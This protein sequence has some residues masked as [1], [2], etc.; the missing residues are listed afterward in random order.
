M[1]EETYEAGDTKRNSRISIPLLI[2]FLLSLGL[3]AYLFYD[4]YNNNYQDGRSLKEINAELEEVLSQ[5]EFSRDSLQSEYDLLSQQYQN[6]YNESEQLKIE[7]T[8]ALQELGQKKV[9]IRQLLARTANP[10]DLIKAKSEIEQLKQQLDD[11]QVKLRQTAEARDKYAKVA[12]VEK[13]NAETLKNQ[14]DRAYKEKQVLEEKVSNATLRISDLR[15]TPLRKRR[16]GMEPTTKSSKVEE[17]EISFIILESPLIKEGEKE[18]KLRIIGTN[19]EVLGANNGLLADSDELFSMK[20]DFTYDGS[21]EKFKLT[22]KQ[23]E[24]YKSGSHFV[25]LWS[26]GKMITRSPFNLD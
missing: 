12:E 5:T 10:K 22:F 1:A 9:R 6:I 26:E 2:L 15:I 18:L 23:E 19:Q 3:N 14:K 8:E 24:A 21:S 13:A 20:K 16:K 11:Y 7:R 25:E 4:W 17:V